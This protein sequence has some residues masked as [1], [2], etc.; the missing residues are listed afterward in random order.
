MFLVWVLWLIAW[1]GFWWA[2]LVWVFFLFG[3]GFCDFCCCGLLLIS[4]FDVSLSFTCFEGCCFGV[5][6]LMFL[7]SAYVVCGW[8]EWF[9]WFSMLWI[10]LARLWFMVVLVL[11]F[12]IVS[13]LTLNL[14]LLIVF[15]DF[16]LWF[17]CLTFW[18]VR[19]RWS[20]RCWILVGFAV[21]NFP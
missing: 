16:V 6:D 8:Y 17:W 7:V 11:C 15:G 20:G 14:M 2:L 18:V 13:W 21:W 19:W 10:Y 5:C 3:L 4:C 1:A 12:W 9:R